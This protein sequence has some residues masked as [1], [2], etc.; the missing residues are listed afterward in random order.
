[1]KTWLNNAHV[2]SA[3]ASANLR[4]WR[5][6][7]HNPVLEKASDEILDTSQGRL[8]CRY[9]QADGTKRTGQLVVL[10]HGW[11]GSSESTYIQLL[12]D[13]L[14]RQGVSV[15]R[16]NFRDHGKTH[17]LNQG[18]FH[19]CRL[20]EV[21]D[22]VR[23]IQD[24][25]K[26]KQLFLAGFS[27]GGNFAVRINSKA[28]EKGISLRQVFA[29]SPVV[30]PY[31][32]ML[33]I[34]ANG[35]YRRYFLRKWKRSLKRK[36]AIYPELFGNRSWRKHNSL[37]SLTRELVL[38]HTSFDSTREYYRGYELTEELLSC[39][40]AET[41]VIIAEDDP[42]IPV[43]DFKRMKKKQ[44][45]RLLVLPTG[46]HCGFIVNWKGHSWIESYISK[47]LEKHR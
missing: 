24:R 12:A 46:G 44:N 31:E 37:D 5:L 18:I 1:M 32:A 14:Y 39:L 16:L 38:Q 6:K 10:L 43:K 42:I 9:T 26:P 29:I 30:D 3:L 40:Q 34:E 15:A 33:A 22:A 17:H 8:L 13:T 47:Q 28:D 2:Q 27:L 25:Y 11:E 4:L 35:F 41:H 20:D 23:L 36:E 21:V 19:S 45:I 7:K